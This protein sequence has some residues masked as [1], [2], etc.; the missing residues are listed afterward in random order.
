MKS[1]RSCKPTVFWVSKP[2]GFQFPRFAGRAADLDPL[3]LLLELV[4]VDGIVQ[5]VGEVAEQVQ[6]VFRGVGDDV[7]LLVRGAAVPFAREAVARGTAAVGGVDLA[8]AV[9]YFLVDGAHGDLVAGVPDAVVSE[10]GEAGAVLAV[11]EAVAD[12]AVELLVGVAV[13]P[14]AV[15]VLQLEGVEQVAGAKPGTTSRTP[16]ARSRCRRPRP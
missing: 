7:G 8:E 13:V 4:A 9:D 16:G 11:A 1:V 2:K 3:V 10:G 14:G 12:D 6:L 5:E 15:V